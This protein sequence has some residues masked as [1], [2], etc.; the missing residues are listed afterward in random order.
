MVRV[1]SPEEIQRM[2]QEHPMHLRR[3]FSITA[4]IDHG[5][6]TA[7]DYL[8]RR[9]GLLSDS[10]AG[11]ARKTDTDEEEQARGIT[12]F[13]SVALLN[14]KFNDKDY[15]LELNDT[16]GHISFT[17]EVSRA[18]R[19]SD[20][21]V[22]LVDAL[23]GVMTQTVTNI[24]LA[25]GNEWT[26]PVLFINKVDRLTKELKLKPDKIIE[27]FGQII[28]EVNEQ[29][30][31]VAPKEFKKSWQVNPGDGRVIFG[32]AKDGWAFTIPMLQAKGVEN[33]RFIIEK[34]D[35]AV[36]KDTDEPIKWLRENFPLD[37]ALLEVIITHLPSPDEAAPYRMKRLWGDRISE[38]KAAKNISDVGEDP[39]KQAAYGML[40]VDRDAPLVG[41][42]TKIFIH[43]RTKRPTLIGRVFSGTLKE[44]DEI[45]LLN[46]RRSLRIRRLGVQ[47]LDSLL[48]V[49]V[50]PAGNLFALE[51]PEIQPAGETFVHIENKDFPPFEKIRYVSD[52]VV[53]RSIKPENP[54][55][56]SK[57]GDVVRKW[58]LADPT[59]VFRKDEDSGEFILSGIDPLQIEILTK[60]IAEEINIKIGIPITVYHESPMSEGFRIRTKCPESLNRI[61]LLIEPLQPEVV[62]LLR[63]GKIDEY[64][65]ERDQAKIL[66]EEASWDRKEGRNI[67]AIE[68]SNILMNLS[69]GVQRLDR[70]KPYVIQAF[71]DFCDASVLA[72][73][74]IMA[75]KVSMY[76]ATVH[77]DP[78]H[79]KGGQ[80]MIMTASALNIS[81][82]SAN[83]GLYEPVLRIDVK[84]PEDTMGSVIS[85]V[86]QH[87]GKITGT[88]TK[89]GNA[90]L[91][92]ELPASEA[93]RGI[94]DELR[95]ATS[96]RAIFGYQFEKFQVLPKN[97]EYET[98]LGIRKRKIEEGRDIAAEPPTLEAF[99]ARI[100][101][102]WQ[103]IMPQLREHLRTL[104]RKAV[105][106][107]FMARLLGEE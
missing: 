42:I 107:E 45:Y 94:A 87:R 72:R 22:L 53:S 78:A 12:I 61:E 76:D 26:K 105:V 21:A 11:Q 36:R 73:E 19:G 16:P 103:S 34:Y 10:Y 60:R 8:M 51:L 14:Y 2:V 102:E 24:H 99:K 3:I 1:K 30:E 54:Q 58:V 15:L 50:V 25:V 37:D 88:E 29:I 75:M 55:D 38:V 64:M 89:G 85:Y 66:A 18:L 68:G 91:S 47:E 97:L 101:P 80:I 71:R 33:A 5:K 13:T 90:F 96:G 74:P 44:G 23:E 43:P 100:Y 84:T 49:G 82:L 95:S 9:A 46:A 63:E 57:L 65:D 104:E 20:G 28:K 40:H 67:W 48:P 39:I 86:T 92:G 7:C 41:M 106:P 27:R 79:T 32:S 35:E 69:R 17:G 4:H 56:L 81:F 6:S 62:Q 77:E 52:P 59:A 83:P 98:I 31:A 70:I 93:S